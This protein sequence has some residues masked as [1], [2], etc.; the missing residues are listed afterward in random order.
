MQEIC[1]KV[2]VTLGVTDT[3]PPGKERG[4]VHSLE[5]LAQGLA[6]AY[7]SGPL[8]LGRS[9]RHGEGVPESWGG[10]WLR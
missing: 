2:N 8:H 5:R 9:Q 7:R 3:E 1:R 10:E 6:A 4:S